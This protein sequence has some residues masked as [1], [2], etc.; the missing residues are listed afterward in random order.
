VNDSSEKEIAPVADVD[1]KLFLDAIQGLHEKIDHGFQRI[2]DCI[3]KTDGETMNRRLSC[4]GRFQNIE[5]RL[6]EGKGK[7]LV[8][9][10]IQRDRKNTW[11][12][13]IRSLA[14]SGLLTMIAYGWY[15]YRLV[16]E[17]KALQ[18]IQ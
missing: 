15:L 12:Y 1:L 18:V 8:R 17:L 14:V 9:T 13:I 6:A 16:A 5:I 2:Y 11:L 3:D 10:E 4:E 7:D